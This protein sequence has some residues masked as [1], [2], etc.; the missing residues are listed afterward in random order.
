[1]RIDLRV[2]SAK[3]AASAETSR[4]Q[5]SSRS[6]ASGAA[7]HADRA[8]LSLSQAKIKDLEQ[9][10][11]NQPEVRTERTQQLRQAIAS[12]SYAV[13]PEHVAEA[14]FSEMLAR[15]SLIR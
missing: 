8:D 13:Q 7:T 3:V 2:G 12:G 9:R 4:A 10:V 1:M 14:F 11:G 15:S 6:G 5:R